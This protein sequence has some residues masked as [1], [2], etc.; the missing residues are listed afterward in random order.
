MVMLDFQGSNLIPGM[1]PTL[2]VIE[3][4]LT[5]VIW[6]RLEQQL[7]GYNAVI[8]GASR[9]LGN[10]GYTTI[11]R[12]GLLLTKNLAGT[13]YVPWGSVAGCATDKIEG[14]LLHAQPTQRAG[15][16]ADRFV[17]YLLVGGNVK[18]KGLCVY[19]SAATGILGHA[20]E[21]VIRSQMFP[22]Y[23][24]DDDPVGHLA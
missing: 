10:T 5:S 15:S 22:A 11:L 7:I 12:P 9:D 16:D 20:Q 17:G 2:E 1:L 19:D 13:K 21:L 6:G 24:F 18:V 23:R 3:S 4:D 8:S 14:V